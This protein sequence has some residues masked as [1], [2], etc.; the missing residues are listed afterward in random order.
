MNRPFN[1]AFIGTGTLAKGVAKEITKS[2]RHRI[3]SVYSRNPE[4]RG[5]FAG[6]YGA[7][8]AETPEEAM[9]APGVDGVYI[10]TPHTS[11]RDLSLMALDL[12]KPVLCEKPVTTDREKAEEQENAL[13]HQAEQDHPYGDVA[14]FFFHGG[15][16]GRVASSRIHTCLLL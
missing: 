2:G 11:H 14:R 9:T 1:W 4:K 5:E 8:S 16:H 10:V 13:H 7:L 6:K 3:V 15:I 12:G